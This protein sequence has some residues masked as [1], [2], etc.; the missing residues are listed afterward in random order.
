MDLALD[1]Y[2]S[3]S[4]NLLTFLLIIFL[5][6]LRW[7]SKNSAHRN[8]SEKKLAPPE[9]SCSRPQIGHLLLLRKPQPVHITLGNIAD[10]YGPLFTIKLGDHRILVVSRW[11]MANECLTTNDKV[12]ANRPKSSLVFEILGYDFALM[13]FSP[14]GP[15]FCHDQAPFQQP[16]RNAQVHSRIG[17]EFCC[18]RVRGRVLTSAVK[19]T[20]ENERCRKALRDFFKLSEDFP[21]EEALPF[22]RLLDLDGKEKAMKRTAKVLDDFSQGWLDEHK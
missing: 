7:I 1:S 14:Y 12:F 16:P 19:S 3:S 17:G 22:L 18:E 8:T 13:G 15:Y 10:G 4:Y 6:S 9:P 20:G 11:D 2:S 21:L 5:L